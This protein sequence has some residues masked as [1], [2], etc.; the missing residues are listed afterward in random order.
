MRI[1]QTFSGKNAKQCLVPAS[2]LWGFAAFSATYVIVKWICSGFG[3]LVGQNK[4]FEERDIGL[5]EIVIVNML[6]T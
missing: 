6:Q 3:L 4:T 1:P 5:L 2:Q